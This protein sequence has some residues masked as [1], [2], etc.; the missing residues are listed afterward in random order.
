MLCAN[1]GCKTRIPRGGPYP[2]CMHHIAPPAFHETAKFWSCCPNK[3]ACD[4]DEFQ[5]APG[6]ET[7][8]CLETKE[9]G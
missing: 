6:Y 1:F 3:K 4:W 5:S 9:N 8:R 2:A 7:G